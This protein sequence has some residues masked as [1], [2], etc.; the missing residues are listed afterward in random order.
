MDRGFPRS[1]LA[2]RQVGRFAVFPI[3]GQGQ[4]LEH[5]LQREANPPSKKDDNC[6]GNE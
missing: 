5:R 1:F 2:Q 6:P 3:E 4:A